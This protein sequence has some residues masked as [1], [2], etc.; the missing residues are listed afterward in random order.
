M[1]TRIFDLPAIKNPLLAIGVALC[2]FVLVNLAFVLDALY[3][4]ALDAALGFFTRANLHEIWRGYSSFKHLSFLAIV[5]FT[6]WLIFRSKLKTFYK[7]SFMF[8]PLSGIYAVI[9][10]TYWRWYGADYFLGALFGLGALAYLYFT[11]KPWLYYFSL[12]LVSLAM[13]LIT[14]TGTDI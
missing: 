1:K 7:A 5:L 9:G 2:G 12:A 10:M 6:S 3:Q 11:K 13:F 4:N 8:V 14:Y